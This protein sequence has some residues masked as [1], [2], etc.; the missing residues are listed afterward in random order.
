MKCPSNN[1]RRCRAANT[2]LAAYRNEEEGR[3]DD[4]GNREEQYR[5]HQHPNEAD[6][7][8][9]WYVGDLKY[10]HLCADHRDQQKYKHRA[11]FGCANA[12]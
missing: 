7:E 1:G 10:I 3:A 5:M 2:R 4:F 8:E 12:F 11:E 6:D 9:G